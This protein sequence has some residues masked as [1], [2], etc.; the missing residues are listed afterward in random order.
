MKTVAISGYFDPLH[1]G[2]IELIKLAKE[3]GDKLVVIVNNDKQEKL[4]K[5]SIF[6]EASERMKVVRGFRCVDMV[7]E[8]VDKDRGISRTLEI[9]RPNIFT[10]GGDQSSENIPEEDSWDLLPSMWVDAITHW[11]DVK[12]P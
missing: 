2:H 1:V 11:Q 9:L 12:A 7:V 4:K 3:L 5:G 6:I 8:S 10:N